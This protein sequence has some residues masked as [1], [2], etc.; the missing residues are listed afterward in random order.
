MRNSNAPTDCGG[1]TYG[2]VCYNT[3]MLTAGP[4]LTAACRLCCSL[5]AT[6]LAFFDSRAFALAAFT[7]ACSPPPT[8]R[9][10]HR[11]TG[12]IRDDRGPQPNTDTVKLTINTL[13]RHYITRKF[14][15]PTSSFRL[16]RTHPWPQGNNSRVAGGEIQVTRGEHNAARAQV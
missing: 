8:H 15:S 3:R 12:L 9:S 7:A 5:K 14:N 6:L 1:A 11:R 10:T 16:P 13:L 2:V 4:V